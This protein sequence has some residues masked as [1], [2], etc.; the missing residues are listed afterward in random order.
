MVWNVL[1]FGKTNVRFIL[2]IL[3]KM[4]CGNQLYFKFGVTVHGVANW[5]LLY[6]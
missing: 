1:K 3:F 6:N 4:W 2:D 5:G